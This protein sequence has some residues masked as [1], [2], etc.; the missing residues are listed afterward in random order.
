MS[1]KKPPAAVRLAIEN[2][3]PLHDFVLAPPK[4]NES[5]VI[6]LWGVRVKHL[7]DPDQAYGW[8]CLG[9]D[10]CREN[11]VIVH[12]PKKSRRRHVTSNQASARG[13]P[14]CV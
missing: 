5:S 8:I 13:A 3:A 6:Y 4:K 14:G 1:F 2:Y 9:S 10:S 7:S 12:L 11:Q